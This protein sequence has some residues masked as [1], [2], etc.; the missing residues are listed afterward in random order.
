MSLDV[1]APSLATMVRCEFA[2]SKL[3]AGQFRNN[4][5]VN[6]KC[7]HSEESDCAACAPGNGE[8]SRVL[9]PDNAH[10]S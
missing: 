5:A 4:I 8:I 7:A 6:M 1:V 3:S 10:A 2:P 9:G